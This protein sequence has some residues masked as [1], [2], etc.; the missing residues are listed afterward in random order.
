MN[1]EKQM[2]LQMLK[3]GKINVKEASDLLEAI[4]DNK[5]KADNL[6]GKIAG[7]V[8]SIIKKATDT[9]QGLDLE[10]SLDLSQFNVKGEVLSEKDL[11]ID[12]EIDQIFI[13]IT[14]G[15]IEVDRADDKAI[16][17][18]EEIW[19]KHKDLEDFLDIEVE[20]NKLRIKVNEAYETSDVR[21]DIRL[22]LG[23]DLYESLEIK[24]VNGKVEVSDVN[25]EDLDID[26][27]NG[28]ITLINTRSNT[29][30]KN[31]NGRIDLKDID[32]SLRVENVNGS[33]YMT[34][35]S[36]D[37]AQ[38]ENVNGNIRVDGLGSK[39]LKAKSNAGVIRV[40]KIKNTENIDLES[41]FGN[42]VVDTTDYEG[43][44][45]ANVY[46]KSINITEKF[47]NK[48]QDGKRYEISTDT[49]K[50]DLLIKIKSGF[51]KIS[52]R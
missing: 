5:N 51:G 25:F 43:H 9:I 7:A 14:N 6:S 48:I 45:R 20:E 31:T 29:N 42:M 24:Q 37:F 12:D 41:G 38:I 4:G 21:S 17:I 13:D 26:T 27:V 39:T 40:F 35:I 3:E 50:T 18:K 28:K 16:T 44:I 2:I 11:R 30:I 10:N 49:E 23:K 34:N 32:G 8:D 36:G 19:A 33:I 1:E 22:S 52:L 15:S 47:V 46:S